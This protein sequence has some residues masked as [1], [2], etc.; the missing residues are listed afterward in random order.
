MAHTDFSS[1]AA[2]VTPRNS[3]R[4]ADRQSDFVSAQR[5]ATYARGGA[6][7]LWEADADGTIRYVSENI[8]EL[9]GLPRISPN[10]AQASWWAAIAREDCDEVERRREASFA[11]G[12]EYNV[13]YRM[14]R[15]DGSLIWIRES[16]AP[17]R[18]ETPAYRGLLEDITTVQHLERRLR[19]KDRT[20]EILANA[21]SVTEAARSFLEMVCHEL[22]WDWGAVWLVDHGDDVLRCAAAYGREEVDVLPFERDSLERSFERGIGLPGRVWSSGQPSWIPDLAEDA[23]FPRVR[24]ALSLGLRSG[25]GF[26]IMLGS[27][28]LGAMEFFSIEPKGRD[29]ELTQL[30]TNLGRQMAQFSERK[31]VEEELRISEEHYRSLAEALPAMVAILAPHGEL[32]Y[33]NRKWSDYTGMNFMQLAAGWPEEVT[34]PDDVERMHEAWDE[35]LR[36]GAPVEIDHR[37]RR[38][39]GTYRW[40]FLRAVALRGGGGRVVRWLG[41]TTD[42]EDRKRAEEAQE[43]LADGTALL[44]SSLNYEAAL[45]NLVGL[46]VPRVADIAAID[47]FE[48]DGTTRRIPSRALDDGKQQL[49]ERI[50]VRDW[51]VGDGESESV[52]DVL[53]DGRSVFF[54]DVSEWRGPLVRRPEAKRA[55]EFAAKSVMMVPLRARNRT[56]GVL[57]LIGAESNRRYSRGD[58]GVAEELG[59]RAG[60]AV[61]NARLY[62]DA[63]RSADDLRKANAAKD[64]FLGLVSHELRTP[65]TTIYGNA[66][67]LRHRAEHLDDETRDLALSDVEQ[68]ADRLHRIIDNMLVLARAESQRNLQTEPL[69]LQHAISRVVDGHRLRHP[70]RPIAGEFAPELPPVSAEPTYVEQVLTNLLNNAE[71]YSGPTDPIDVTATTEDGVVA[72]RVLDRGRGIDPDETDLIFGAFYRSSRTAAG[73]SGA[74]IGLAVCKRLV[75][76]Q[77]G[78]IWAR[79][80]ADGPGAEFGFAL[81]RVTEADA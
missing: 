17:T 65:I 71:K 3:E 34:H 66:Q 29:G 47:V 72:V 1:K 61:D 26:P 4:D 69:L 39:D 27:Q 43:F 5:L 73:A 11:T 20:A 23:N 79:P 78:W 24:S 37:I 51:P 42:I 70:E 32:T 33:A 9:L 56:I 58:L 25:A 68:E 57:S 50:H 64:E 76:A 16:G 7:V 15:S 63:Q 21:G 13:S 52:S 36:S 12:R 18:G 46:L 67:V 74:G 60:I 40:H 31:A 28:V 38:K 19:I 59:R 30:M 35:S 53:T 81:P 77:G 10:E 6:P 44:A 54:P 2:I 22:T 80:R 48:P 49:L 14:I 75:E 41:T 8:A 45:R 55:L 62:Q